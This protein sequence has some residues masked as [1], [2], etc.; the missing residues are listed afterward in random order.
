MRILHVTEQ[1]Y[2]SSGVS[3]FC[4]ELCEALLGQG[5]RVR[6][7]LQQ[8]DYPS[9]YPVAHEEILTTVEDVLHDRNRFDWDVVHINGVWNW[10]YHQIASIAYKRGVPVVWSPHGSLTPWALHHK[11]LKKQIAWHVYQKRDLQRASL[12]HVTAQSEVKDMR[13]LGLQNELIVQPLGVN[14]RWSEDEL[15]KIKNGMKE[16][17]ILFLSRL[18][19]KKGIDNLIK[20]WAKIKREVGQGAVDG[21]KIEIVGEDSF[22]G[23]GAELKRQCVAMGVEDDFVFRGAVYG[24]ERELAYARARLFVLPS[25]SENFG[26]VVVEALANG[27][28]VITTTGTPWQSLQVNRCGWWIDVGVEPLACVLKEAMSLDDAMLRAMG[29]RG[30]EWMRRDFDW[31]AIGAK[32][33]VTYEWY[34][35]KGDKPDWIVDD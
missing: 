19:P 28:P 16:K 17:R 7:A 18:H 13:R 21:W 1:R 5:V 31:V 34:C 25:H 2:R 23:Y 9:P 4:V 3:V 11:W 29:A 27:T 14:F 30:R 8:P 12:L 26:S 35:G 6:I 32:M 24:D 10:P 33:K 20:A 22:P 15:H